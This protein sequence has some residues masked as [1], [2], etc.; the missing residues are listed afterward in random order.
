MLHILNSAV[1]YKWN[2]MY[3][4]IGNYLSYLNYIKED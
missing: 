4:N 1:V 2:P 3:K